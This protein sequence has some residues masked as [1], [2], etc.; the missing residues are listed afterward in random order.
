ML[1]NEQNQ[2]ITPQQESPQSPEAV[3]DEAPIPPADSTPIDMPP[4]A[5]EAPRDAFTPVPVEDQNGAV[6]EP[7]NKEAEPPKEPEVIEESV[8]EPIQAIPAVTAPAPQ[9]SATAQTQSLAQQDERGFIRSL[10]IKAQ[11]KIQF[12]KQKKLEKLI[13]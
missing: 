5:P 7:E 6:N 11:A 12:N 2:D 10:L 1:G 8:P 4:V 13:Q 9:T 3:A